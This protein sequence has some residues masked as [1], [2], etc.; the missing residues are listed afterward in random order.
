MNGFCQSLKTRTFSRTIYTRNASYMI[1][2]FNCCIR[3]SLVIFD[4]KLFYPYHFIPSDTLYHESM[5]TTTGETNVLH[6]K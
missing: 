6:A 2:K 4:T 1:A 5:Q 3:E